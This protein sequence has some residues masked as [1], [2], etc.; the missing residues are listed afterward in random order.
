VSKVNLSPSELVKNSWSYTS[1]PSICH[2]GV[3]RDNFTCTRCIMQT[4]LKVLHN[5]ISN[6]SRNYMC[7]FFNLFIQKFNF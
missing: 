6:E 1:N 2:H 5:A 7:R 4:V 3:D